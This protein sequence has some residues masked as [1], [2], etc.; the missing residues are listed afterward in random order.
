[1]SSARGGG[2]YRTL[3]EDRRDVPPVG[4]RASGGTR[5][6]FFRRA[7]YVA[8]AASASVGLGYCVQQALPPA[9]IAQAESIIRLVAGLEATLLALVLGLL[10]ST[11]H[12][13]FNAQLHQW[14]TIG[15]AILSLDRAF[16]ELGPVGEPGRRALPQILNRM[17]ARFWTRRADGHRTID[18]DNL[19]E[20]D[21]LMRSTL[22][23]LRLIGDDHKRRVQTCEE[24]FSLIFET[25]LTMMRSI[26]NPVPHLLFNSVA[27]WTCMLFFGFG[28]LSPINFLTGFVAMLGAIAVASAVFLVLE[29]SD[30]YVGVFQMPTSGLEK[31]LQVLNFRHRK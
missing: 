19:A 24:M 1:V 20:E 29:L 13:L 8:A 18:F 15:R 5:L 22:P 16:A 26:V 3:E 9:D 10:I 14:Q 2:S 27:A 4:M 11:C 31:L 7:T 28:M 25:Q 30:P 17:R 12:G 23:S 6:N 21:S